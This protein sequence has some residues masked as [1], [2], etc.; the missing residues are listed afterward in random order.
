MDILHQ[1]VWNELKNTLAE[2]DEQN[3]RAALNQ[4]VDKGRLNWLR[5]KIIDLCARLDKLDNPSPFFYP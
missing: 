2:W 1:A 5:A 3:N 4:Y